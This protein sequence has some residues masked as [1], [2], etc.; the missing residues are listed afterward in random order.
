M[1]AA[2]Y[3]R[4]STLDQA[5]EGYSL[6]AQRAALERWAAFIPVSDSNRARFAAKLRRMSLSSIGSP[7]Y[8]YTLYTYGEEC[9][10]KSKK[11][12]L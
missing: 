3:I 4:V 12:L 7:P 1:R 11:F 5:R 2:I 6:A 10:E 8:I 9:Q